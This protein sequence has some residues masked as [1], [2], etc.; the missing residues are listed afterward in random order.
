MFSILF[1]RYFSRISVFYTMF[2]SNTIIK[3][4]AFSLVTIVSQYV[5]AQNLLDTTSRKADNN[6]TNFF[7]KE[8][9]TFYYGG[10]SDFT[11][12][13]IS[14]GLD[15]ELKYDFPKKQANTINAPT[16]V[17]YQYH[18]I[19]RISIGLVYCVSSVKTPDLEYP[20]LQN[21][22][23]VIV[24][25]YE[26]NINSFLGSVDY[27]WY[28]RNAAKSSLSLY[29]GLALGVYDVNFRTQVTGGD[30][31]NLPEYNF[32]AGSNGWQITLIGI[33][34][35]FNFKLLKQFGYTANLGVGTNVI[36]VSLGATYTM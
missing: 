19:N 12:R 32:S 22:D 4:I 6:K 11:N 23:E 8:S 25:H 35:S 13:Q 2:Q 31:A 17:G 21:P 20:D 9:I 28:N 10:G 34:Q 24:F 36:G 14:N 1:Y 16:F 29:S 30:G 15:E 7:N 33:K 3:G 18:V 5:S 27:H 26:V